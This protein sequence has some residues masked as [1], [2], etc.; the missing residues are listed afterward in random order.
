MYSLKLGFIGKYNKKKWF[1]FKYAE[2][3]Q[4]KEYITIE[5]RERERKDIERKRKKINYLFQLIIICLNISKQ[6]LHFQ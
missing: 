4:P 3:Q 5:E 6:F 2:D 1:A